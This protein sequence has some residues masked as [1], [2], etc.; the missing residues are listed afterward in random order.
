[1][2][3]EKIIRYSDNVNVTSIHAFAEKV[4]LVT[5]GAD[6]IGKA[7]ALQLALQGSYVLVGVPT[8]KAED[9]SI[10]ELKALGT[11]A[12]AISADL[13][14]AEG[15][16]HLVAG[17]EKAF[18]R[19]DLLVNCAKTDV[20]SAFMDTSEGDLNDA[21]AGRLIPLYFVT[22]AAVRLMS[23]RPKPRIV[24]IFPEGDANE[25]PI[26]AGLHA[27]A[28]AIMDQLSRTL[29]DKFRVNSIKVSEEMTHGD[30]DPELF[31]PTPKVSPDDVARI[32]LFLLSGEAKA[33]NGEVIT[34]N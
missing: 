3:C 12:A 28:L 17:V 19:L 26:T 4:A 14:T 23:D 9:S 24:S 8:G 30:G 11:L 21:V 18:G 20:H 33:M 16:K 34:L 15:A 6:P 27:A 32:A 29:P 10:E 7:I 2:D 13:T 25:D 31:R 22:Q 1:M 5:D